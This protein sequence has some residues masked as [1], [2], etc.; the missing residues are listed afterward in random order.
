MRKLAP[1]AVFVFAAASLAA[2]AALSQPPE[3]TYD[4]APAADEAPVADAAPAESDV[5]SEDDLNASPFPAGLHAALVKK[6]CT[7]CHA[8]RVMLD[9]TFTREDAERYYKNMVSE[10]LSTDQAQKIIAY[11]T[12][13]MGVEN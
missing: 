12:T 5:L 4:L 7:Q 13:T 6:V 2:G 3:P 9:M 1:Y 11:L 10:D 8:A